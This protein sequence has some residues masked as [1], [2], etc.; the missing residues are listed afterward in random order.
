MRYVF[1]IAA[2]LSDPIQPSRFFSFIR[3]LYSSFSI[4]CKGLPAIPCEYPYCPAVHP[5][6]HN[7]FFALG[8][9]YHFSFFVEVIPHGGKRP[10]N[11]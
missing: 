10:F 7:L 3:D 9:H 4:R 5:S 11:V 1:S 8:L 6:L 2:R